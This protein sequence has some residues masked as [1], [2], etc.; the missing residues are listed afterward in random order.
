M[1]PVKKSVS[2]GV[3]E[4]LLTHGR[5]EESHDMRQMV[6][7]IMLKDNLVDMRLQRLNKLLCCGL[8]DHIYKPIPVNDHDVLLRQRISI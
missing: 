2:T 7:T 1:K 3:I 8:R 6:R 4:H 5:F